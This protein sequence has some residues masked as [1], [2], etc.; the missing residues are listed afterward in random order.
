MT[1]LAKSLAAEAGFVSTADRMRATT[2]VR[3]VPTKV[4]GIR[5]VGS[6]LMPEG[7][8]A[9]ATEGGAMILPPIGAPYYLAFGAFPPPEFKL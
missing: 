1:P 8:V 5:L 4:H 6:P 3:S 9:L 7:Y 2:Q